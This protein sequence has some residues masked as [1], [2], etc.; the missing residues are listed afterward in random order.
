[1]AMEFAGRVHS[2]V[3]MLDRMDRMGAGSQREA[4]GLDINRAFF[5]SFNPLIRSFFHSSI[6]LSFQ[7]FT[8]YAQQAASKCLAQS[9]ASLVSTLTPH[10]TKLAHL[11]HWHQ[12]TSV[13]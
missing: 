10:P 5:S 11:T 8:L 4:D 2:Q 12:V 3:A 1:M 9:P 13:S 7:P 6:L